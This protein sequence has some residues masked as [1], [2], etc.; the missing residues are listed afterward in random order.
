MKTETELLE[1]YA[2][3][4][5]TRSVRVIKEYVPAVIQYIQP[6]KRPLMMAK[7]EFPEYL[8]E[9]FNGQRIQV[10]IE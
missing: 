10:P 4:C 9:E 6:G 3:A 1:L 2:E 5:K 7:N 8:Q